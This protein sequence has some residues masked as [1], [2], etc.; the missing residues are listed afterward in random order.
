MTQINVR[1]AVSIASESPL[2]RPLE[3]K[4]NSNDTV[5]AV[6]EQ[7]LAIEPL[8]FPDRDL[9]LNGVRLKEEATLSQAG[10]NENDTLVLLV[11]ASEEV[12]VGQLFALLQEEDLSLEN[13]ESA[14]ERRHGTSVAR[15]MLLLG[16]GDEK[17][18]DFVARQTIFGAED[19]LSTMTSQASEK[20]RRS[21]LNNVCNI[22]D[23]LT[24]S[25][26]NE[27]ESS[28]DRLVVNISVRIDTPY[29]SST[30]AVLTL[31]LRSDELVA[32][33]KQ[34]V[35]TTELIPFPDQIL[36]FGGQVLPDMLTLCESGVKDGSFVDFVVRASE[37]IFVEQL[38]DLVV[39]RPNLDLSPNQL[40]ML[41]F[42]RYNA[43]AN[44]ALK[45]LGCGWGEKFRDFLRRQPRF[46]VDKG[47]VVV[48]VLPSVASHAY[49]SHNQVFLNLH[50]QIT[51]TSAI[52][53]VTMALDGACQVVTNALF[54]NVDRVAKGGSAV[55]NTAIL[56]S[57]TAEGVIL[58]TGLP[59]TGLEKIMPKLLSTATAALKEKLL[60]AAGVEGVWTAGE[61]VRVRLEGPFEV[62]F[63]FAPSLGSTHSQ[64][65]RAACERLAKPANREQREL[66]RKVY[67]SS[68]AERKILFVQQMPEPVKMTVR[69]LKWWREQRTWSSIKT[70]PSDDLLTFG[71]AWSHLET[72]PADLYTAVMNA[73]YVLGRFMELRASWTAD[74]LCY[75]KSDVSE[76]MWHERPLLMDPVIPFANLADR[77]SF[78][79]IE[80][81]AYAQNTNLL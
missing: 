54:L 30:L 56:G 40:G 1:V 3:L 23:V 8:P 34:R 16:I 66:E 52:E 60:G 48:T 68:L 50:A 36:V 37:E 78:D 51:N 55:M 80:M 32:N 25:T 62:D 26:S 43:S 61:A 17:F 35:S 41:Y 33:V 4:V 13:L 53:R 77:K 20:A 6:Q 18:S 45:I 59:P 44:Q 63:R 47:R 31:K 9:F 65:L 69:M 49:S 15:T 7:V 10:V 11:K 81:M 19:D 28:L 22:A 38:I 12:F 72:Q 67:A 64:R 29:K 71:A 42:Y 2:D 46:S 75:S 73:L 79:P 57:M 21:I 14:F 39:S 24:G 76:A 5:E 74:T 27:A 70:W 58:L